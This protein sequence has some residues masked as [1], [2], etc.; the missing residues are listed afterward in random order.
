MEKLTFSPKQNTSCLRGYVTN[1]YSQIIT[2]KNCQGN[3][4]GS[5]FNSTFTF[6][7]PSLPGKSRAN[8]YLYKHNEQTQT[9][10][11]HSH[12]KLQFNWA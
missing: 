10:S 12:V 1:Y 5:K 4:S 3:I 7:H 11:V 8:N 2:K 6:N 9:S